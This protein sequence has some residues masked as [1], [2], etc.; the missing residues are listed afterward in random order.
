MIN[1]IQ[2]TLGC[3]VIEQDYIVPNEFPMY[4][5]NVYSYK[6]YTING[7][8]CLAVK[9][10]DFSLSGY[11]KQ[12]TKIAELTGL[13][14]ILDLDKIT[15]YQR[16]AL[17]NDRIPFVVNGTQLYLPFLAISLTEKYNKTEKTEKFS[18][19]TQLVFLYAYYKKEF[20][21]VTELSKIL[22][23]SVMSIN[24]AYNELISCNLVKFQVKGRKKS[25]S[26]V[27]PY[28][29]LLKAAEQY[30][31]DPVTKKYHCN[32]LYDFTDN[33]KSGLYALSE[34]TMLEISEAEKCYAVTKKQASITKLQNKEI[35]PDDRNAVTV[36]CWSYD[37]SLL[38]KDDCVDD[39]SLILTLKDN[40]DERVQMEVDELRRKYKW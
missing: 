18:P 16:K 5:K 36:E 14:A 23:Y 37:P 12:R 9:P 20:L 40:D 33:L 1:Y 15:P 30:M 38:T 17:I 7:V 25:F 8:K 28:V 34:K 31:I 2:E 19:V 21:P 26:P 4:L 35:D 11:K 13:N 10:Y 24:R 32:K 39:I 27:L 22:G 6:R 3:N 29:E